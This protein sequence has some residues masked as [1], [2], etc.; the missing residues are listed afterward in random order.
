MFKCSAEV[1]LIVTALFC[2]GAPIA[3]AQN[4]QTVDTRIGKLDFE[5]GV[6][7]KATLKTL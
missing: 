6:L 5:F 4:T 2:A 1:F 7:T 3:V